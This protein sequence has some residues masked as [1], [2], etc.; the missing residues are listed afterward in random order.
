M[1]DDPSSDVAAAK[2][3]ED[4][5]PSVTAVADEPAVTRERAPEI[6]SGD[7]LAGRYQIEA[8]LGKGGS[9]VVLR[10][11][12]RVSATVVAVKVLKP[13]LTHDPR[14]EKRFQRELRLGRPVRHP[15]VCRIFDIGDAE[16]YRFLTM[17]YA[18]SGTL[19][20]LIKKNA[21]LRPFSQPPPGAAGGIAR[22]GGTPRAGGAP[23]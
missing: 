9:G 23:P 2:L 11:Y 22:L 21:P 3:D 14:W 6:K 15:N 13:G 16:G 17:E 18:T 12:D 20:D 1:G 4:E 19:R 7:L 8:L 5:D 10:A